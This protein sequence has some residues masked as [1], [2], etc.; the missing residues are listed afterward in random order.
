MGT[1][2]SDI[3]G[4]RLAE[5]VSNNIIPQ[6]QLSVD[7]LLKT[8]KKYISKTIEAQGKEFAEGL[9]QLNDLKNRLI[10]VNH[11]AHP[12]TERDVSRVFPPSSTSNNS[13]VNP[14]SHINN[15]T[16]EFLS[17]EDAARLRDAHCP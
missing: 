2:I 5:E 7:N 11:S 9:K 3:V 15:Y 10:S 13:S 12:N 4:E 8:R 16:E 6:F 17:T 14:T 1:A